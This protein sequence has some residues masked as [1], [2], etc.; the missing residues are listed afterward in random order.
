MR[1]WIV[2]LFLAAAF[3]VG[4]AAQPLPS[5]QPF[6]VNPLQFGTHERRMPSQAIVITDGSGTMYE[7]RTFPDAKALTQ[8]FVQS[9]PEGSSRG[10]F[11]GGYEASLIGFGGSERIQS[12]LASF[13]RDA[14]AG[15]AQSLRVLGDPK[16]YGGTTPLNA[17]FGEVEQSLVGKKGLAAIVIFSDGLPQE[18]PGA[19]EAS[20]TQAAQRLIENYAG[21]VCIH[22]VHLGDN[23]T[24]AR[25]LAS[26]ASLTSCGSSRLAADI[27]GPKTFMGFTR[28]VFA[29]KAVA[30][31]APDVCQGRIVLRGIE[32]AF[33]R[34]E[35][36][37]ISA[38]ILDFAAVQMKMCP[39]VSIEVQGHTDGV[40]SNEYNLGLGQRRADSVR[41]HFVAKG[42]QSSRLSTKSFGE[43]SPV[44]ANSTDDGRRLNRRVELHAKK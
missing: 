8:A 11:Q 40:G 14:L 44:A 26:L 22:T 32:F 5:R 27:P 6:S 18:T 35:V 31:A 16:G 4:C 39:K 42:I 43:S 15:T 36:S 7:H 25:Y 19:T 38:V 41:R 23:P 34:A 21:E 28:E 13:D 10:K 20:T 33:D 1:T 3:G 37:E 2:F 30:A 17:I 29:G 12:P 9:M 24:G